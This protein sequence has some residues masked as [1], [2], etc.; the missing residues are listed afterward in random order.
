MSPVS[1]DRTT[2]P[3]GQRCTFY[4]SPPATDGQLRSTSHLVLVSRAENLLSLCNS[5][6][7]LDPLSL[8]PSPKKG[9]YPPSLFS[10]PSLGYQ[11]SQRNYTVS[12]LPTLLWAQVFLLQPFLLHNYLNLASL[13]PPTVISWPASGP[14]PPTFP[15]S[16]FSAYLVAGKLSDASWQPLITRL[17]VLMGPVFASRLCPPG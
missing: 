2:Q 1:P 5:S 14:L 15:S 7:R 3:S 4:I 8:P 9:K 17:L 13:H 10:S 6:P 11:V 16:F 12:T